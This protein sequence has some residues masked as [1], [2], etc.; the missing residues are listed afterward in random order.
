MRGEVHSDEETKILA[1]KIIPSF[2]RKRKISTV[3][4]R[5]VMVCEQR[6]PRRWDARRNALCSV[7][8]KESQD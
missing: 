7:D 1:G 8:W 6:N 2:N 4:Q 5:N 3:V